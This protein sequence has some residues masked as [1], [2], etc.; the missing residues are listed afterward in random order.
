VSDRA[1]AFLD[2]WEFAHITIVAQSK[3]AEEARRLAPQCREDAAKAG[4]S[5]QD[6]EDA[7]DGDLIGNMVRALDTAALR[8]LA[9]DQWADQERDA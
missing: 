7:V 8:R 4:I 5:Q 2:G 3:R 1:T 9:R 6:L